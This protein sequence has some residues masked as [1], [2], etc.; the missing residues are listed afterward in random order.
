M[1]ARFGTPLE[2]SGYGPG[3]KDFKTIV[4]YKLQNFIKLKNSAEGYFKYVYNN[5]LKDIAINYCWLLKRFT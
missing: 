4:N 3:L 5:S 2:K 1:H